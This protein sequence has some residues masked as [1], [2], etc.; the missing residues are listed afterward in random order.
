MGIIKVG[1]IRMYG[2]H[3]CLPEEEKIGGYYDVNVELETD[4]SGAEKT[5]NLKQTVDY[6]DVYNIIIREM[7]IRSK[8]IEHVAARMADALKKEI[9]GI[10]QLSLELTKIAP[11]M[12]GDVAMVSVIVE[13]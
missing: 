3:G 8:L 1:P 7:K 10:E 13:R 2:Y 6:C 9:K 4:F 11:P 5:D 12:N